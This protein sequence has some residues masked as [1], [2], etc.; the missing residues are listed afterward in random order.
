VA[1]PPPLEE[2]IMNQHVG[3]ILALHLS[4]SIMVSTTT[5]TTVPIRKS[6]VLYGR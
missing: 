5:K 3:H 1:Q 4:S 6:T 2:E